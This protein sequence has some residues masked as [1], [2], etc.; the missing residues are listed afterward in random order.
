MSTAPSLGYTIEEC[1]ITLDALVD[2][3]KRGVITEAF[4]CGTAATIVGIGSFLLDTGEEIPV[5]TGG[6]GPA[7][8]TLYD[9]LTGIQFGRYPDPLGWI[10]KV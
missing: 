1:D 10:T 5:G 7:T 9:R 4:A 2:Q 6:S 8:D 3:M